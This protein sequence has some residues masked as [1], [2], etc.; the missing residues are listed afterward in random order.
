MAIADERPLVSIPDVRNFWDRHPVSA[1]AIPYAPGTPEYFRAYDALREINE[2]PAFSNRLHE[3]KK[4]AGKRVADFGCGNGYVLSRYALARADVFG[5][6]LTPKAIEL[7]EARFSQAGLTGHFSV[8]NLEELPF[9]DNFFDCVCCM[10]VL[11]HTPDPAKALRE[12][13]RVLKPGGQL[14]LMVYHRHSALYQFKFRLLSRLQGKSRQTLV[15]EVDGPGNPKGDVYSRAELS[16]ALREFENIQLFADLLQG[17]MLLPKLGR[18]LPDWLLKPFARRWG[19]FL[20]A[21]AKKP[22]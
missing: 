10:G 20:Y 16:R 7:S 22:A 18:F 8:G 19:W 14:I 2:T 3:F 13:L 6:D 12:F 9:T 1:S 15:N 21:T 17:W 11:H 5:L 4:F